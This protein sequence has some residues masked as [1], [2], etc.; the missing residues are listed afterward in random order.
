MMKIHANKNEF[1]TA[2]D[3]AESLT[4]A[5]HVT[6]VHAMKTVIAQPAPAAL[7]GYTMVND[8][9]RPLD[10][11]KSTPLREGEKIII[12][13]GRHVTGYLHFTLG[14]EGRGNDSPTRLR[15]VYG[16]VPTDVVE[17]FYPYHGKLSAGW[18]PDEVMTIQHLPQAVTIPKRHAF[19]YVSI[20]IQAASRNFGLTFRDIYVNAVSSAGYDRHKPAAYDSSLWQRLDE[21][22]LETLR[23][24]MQTCF[25]DGPRR[26][27]RLWMGD[28]RLQ[29]L[30]NYVSF[31]QNDLVKRCLY[32][33]AGSLNE[34]GLMTACVYE[35]PKPHPGE[36]CMLDYAALFGPTL[37]DYYQVT[38]DR[39]TANRLLA[40][41]INQLNIIC[42]KYVDNTGYFHVPEKPFCF[43]DWQKGLDK[44]AA[45]QGIIIYS[46][47]EVVALAE[48]LGR[49]ESC[50]SL[51]IFL[52]KMLI[53][54]STFWDETQ[55]C[56]TSG[57]Q[58]QVS[59]ASQIW[60]VLADVTSREQQQRAL[61]TIMQ[62]SDAVTPM[63]P[64]LYHHMVSA[65][66][67]C[68]LSERAKSLVLEYWG[69]M[70][71]GGVD[72]F[73]EAFS[74]SDYAISPY[75]SKHINSYCHAWSCTPAYFIRHRFTRA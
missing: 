23:E 28:L 64:Y 31:E 35:K 43:V 46:C 1:M 50:Q 42:T 57:P 65:L 45:M 26:D 52:D 73:W 29:A 44:H 8:E 22:S 13:F 14:W 71:E 67:H 6:Q 17:P 10:K 59:W 41:A 55:Q 66:V 33:F 68:Q 24:C 48:Q 74:P 47:R 63:T 62:H 32:L 25:E 53:A 12:D 70:A 18:L 54:A 3:M 40:V 9:V 30:T 11:I 60:L 49:G 51:L 61:T 37:A 69:A 34:H 16:E 20:E 72:T 21:I 38:K 58:R 27:Q 7:L 56:F 19:R 75:G 15:L 4:P 39:E 2:Y 36:G 5:L